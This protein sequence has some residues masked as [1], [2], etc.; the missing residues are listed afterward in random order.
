MTA[1]FNF[2]HHLLKR[3]EP[4]MWDTIS[5]AQNHAA[6]QSLPAFPSEYKFCPSESSPTTLLPFTCSARMEIESILII[7]LLFYFPLDTPSASDLHH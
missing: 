7:A 1:F 4:G 3:T 2:L 6:S 5:P